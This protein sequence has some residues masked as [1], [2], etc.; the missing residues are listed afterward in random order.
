MPDIMPLVHRVVDDVRGLAEPVDVE[1]VS[2]AVEAV[3]ASS[4]WVDVARSFMRYRLERA[5]VRA[6]RL[7]PDD[8]AISGYIHVG[9]YARYLGDAQRRELFV[10][11]VARD[12]NMHLRRWPEL[13][14]EIR[15]A[16]SYVYEKM[17]MPSMRSM[18]FGGLAIEKDNARIYNCSFGHL[19]RWRAFQEMFYLLLCGCG[20][21]Y[22]VQWQ[23]VDQLG[24]LHAVDPGDVCH[25]TIDDSIKGWAD[26]LGYLLESYHGDR[27]CYVEFNY[28]QIRA[29]GT[30]LKTSGGLAPGHLPLKRCLEAVRGVLDGAVGR[31]MRPIECH[32]IMCHTAL[33]VL[34]GGIRRSAMIALF[35]PEDTEMLYSKTRG[36]FRPAGSGGDAGLNAQ[37]EMANNSACLLRATAT[38]EVFDRI[39]RVAATNY[40]CPG[41]YFTNN[42]DYG[43]N[44]CG[45]IG[46]WPMINKCRDCDAWSS[47]DLDCC[48]SC[49]GQDLRMMSGISFCNLTEVNCAG[50]VDADDLYARV[51][52]MAFIGTLQAGYDSFPYLG[53][54]TEAIVRREALLGVGLTG[55]MDNTGLVL[56]PKV[57]GRAARVAV[58]ENIRVA[59]LVGISSA[60]RVT[61]VKPSGTSSLELGG[62]G[63]GIH[64]RWARRYIQRVTANPLEPQAV[65]FRRVNP[66]MVEVKPNGDWAICFPIQA[67]DDALTVKESTAMEFLDAVFMVYEHWIEPGTARPSSS[68]GMTHNVSCTVTV[69][70][71]ELEGVIARVWDERHRVAAMTFAPYL[72][73]ERFRY[74]PRQAVAGPRDEARWNELIRLYKPIDWAA[75]RE[76]TDT[77]TLSSEPA[78]KGNVCEIL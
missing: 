8:G 47:P 18:Q 69:R 58:D 37:R 17:G 14:G 64:P 41:F 2:D 61:T 19:S 34:A 65:Y 38:R 51:K 15:G 5:V 49:S 52:A 35:S 1:A 45:E 76:E 29:E 32:D 71:S 24:E 21:G 27:N 67:A 66:H 59:A 50:A 30:P 46:M 43:P 70:D 31:K 63:S 7:R 23:H 78:C 13:E 36:V 10:E 39:V 11:T 75:F 74:A 68:P 44:P 20:V 55:I 22:S 40:G 25:Y 77:T 4:G 42:L 60:A 48:E 33:A 6:E 72:I 62:V 73:D 16:F 53:D 56:N 26:A 9:K 3:L 12:E 28:S 54:V 57:L